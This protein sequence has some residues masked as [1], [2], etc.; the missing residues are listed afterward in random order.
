MNYNLKRVLLIFLVFIISSS[1]ATATIDLTGLYDK[2]GTIYTYPNQVTWGDDL[3]LDGSMIASSHLNYPSTDIKDLFKYGIDS[4]EY[5]ALTEVYQFGTLQFN[6]SQ[7]L[8]ADSINLT[9]YYSTTAANGYWKELPI[10]EDQTQ[11]FTQ[12]GMVNI[13][14]NH[15]ELDEWVGLGPAI[16]YKGYKIIGYVHSVSNLTV[17]PSIEG[18]W[19]G[20][21]SIEIMDE[22]IDL[23][24]LHIAVNNESIIEKTNTRSYII[25]ENIFLDNATLTINDGR[26]VDIGIETQDGRVLII[27]F[28]SN[29]ILNIGTEGGEG[30]SLI[31]A[32]PTGH[33]GNTFRMT[34]NAYNS[35]WRQTY[36]M[37]S[38]YNSGELNL[39]NFILSGQQQFLMQGS[40]TIKDM[41]TIDAFLYTYSSSYDFN[42]L[43]L[44]GESA[45]VCGWNRIVK[46]TGADFSENTNPNYMINLGAARATFELT[47]QKGL[48]T[49]KL[50]AKYYGAGTDTGNDGHTYQ[51]VTTDIN[52]FNVYGEEIENAEITITNGNGD[53]YSDTTNSTGSI[54][55]QRILTIDTYHKGPSTTSYIYQ[56][57]S[58]YKQEDYFGL[59]NITI[60]HPDYANIK[61]INYNLTAPQEW[62]LT[63]MPFEFK[64]IIIHNDAT[65]SLI[66]G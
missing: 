20:T 40:G 17:E 60:S 33:I 7:A 59:V 11:N 1:I 65:E 52:L 30:A 63:M 46:I 37:T 16:A 43:K 41:T 23:Y 14:F 55:Q 38:Y 34:I 19:I 28:T 64:E 48:N 27:G 39:D 53:I 24:S 10:I 8:V 51:F 2:T 21:N 29:E 36:G 15:S 3:S 56:N 61:Y 26:H 4:G 49:D 5:I 47:N 13:T 6:V 18:L 50:V 25:H 42:G 62:S 45:L 54:D 66:I 22:E 31:Y 12:T 35:K 57:P 58:L 44:K 9:W 32:G